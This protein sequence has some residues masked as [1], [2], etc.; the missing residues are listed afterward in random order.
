MFNLIPVEQNRVIS[1]KEFDKTL[2]NVTYSKELGSK[3]FNYINYLPAYSQKNWLKYADN[4]LLQRN[5]FNDYFNVTHKALDAE[6]TQIELIFSACDASLAP[7]AA[8]VGLPYWFYEYK[9]EDN[10]KMTVNS[11]TGAYS[12]VD[13][14]DLE[15]G[16]Y[17]FVA[18]NLSKVFQVIDNRNGFLNTGFSANSQDWQW[19]DMDYESQE[20]AYIAS[21]ETVTGEAY[22]LRSGGVLFSNTTGQPFKA[23][24]FT[25][26]LTFTQLIEQY[27]KTTTGL[28][29]EPLV[30]QAFF[31]VTT[32]EFYNLTSNTVYVPSLGLN[33][34]VNKVEQF[35]SKGLTR[36]ELIRI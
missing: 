21:M 8:K 30:I 27:F 14:N 3:D 11:S 13:S 36:V 5:D 2:E 33:F 4:E 18:G 9:R 29:L 34:Y 1:F 31:N 12:T 32:R 20:N 35:K 6:G 23:A 19:L 24:Q 7:G 26:A 25:A 28:L 15:V 17:V 16:D 10:N 22:N